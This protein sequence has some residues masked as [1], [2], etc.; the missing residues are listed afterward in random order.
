MATNKPITIANPIDGVSGC[1]P[2]LDIIHNQIH[3]G[4]HYFTSHYEKIGAGSAVNILI[5]TGSKRVH[6]IGEI[7]T[8]NSGMGYFS[9]NPNAT[10]S[11]STVITEYNNDAASTNVA[12]C[13][14]VVNGTYTSS[15]TV[16]RYYL[17]GSTGTNK[18][19]V[20]NTA[21]EANEAILA[22]NT[23]YLIRF[24]ADSAS[25]RTVIRTSFYETD[26]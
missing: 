2:V 1:I 19:S 12:S 9:V 14:T 5:T 21:G 24:V 10:A 8:D 16:L 13:S 18:A 26:A 22:V 11:D 23:K 17:L 15:G 6:I 20:G 7:V 3:E 4:N 25:T